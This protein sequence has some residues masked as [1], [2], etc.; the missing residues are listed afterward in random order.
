MNFGRYQ[1]QPWLSR[2]L[3]FIKPNQVGKQIPAFP[4]SRS[5]APA[6]TAR[7]VAA[8]LPIISRR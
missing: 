7:L 5:A 8:A 1:K 4:N 2:K 6:V 3:N